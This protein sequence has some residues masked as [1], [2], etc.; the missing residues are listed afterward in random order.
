MDDAA[1]PLQRPAPAGATRAPQRRQAAFGFIFASALMNSVSFGIMI[2]ILPNLIRQFTGGDT[3]AAS[4]WNMVFGASWGLMQFFVGP[5]LGMLSDRVGRRPVLL[6]SFFG[7]AV[8]F[9]FMAFAPS[10][11][12]LYVGR[13][14]NGMTAS[15][16]STAG[17]YLADVTAPE[18]RAKSF[19]MLTSA[20]SFGFII[21]PT[22]GG[23][24]GEHSLRLPF[25]AAA[26][27]TAVNWFYGLL[28]LPESLPPERRLKA[29][30]WARANPLGSLRLLRGHPGLLGLAGVGFLFQLAQIVLPTI[31]VLYTTYRYGWTPGV[32]GLTFLLTGVLGVIVQMFLVGPAVAGLGERRVVLL[33]LLAGASGFVWYGA[34][35][36][37]WAYL[38][39]APIFALSG[40][41]MPGLQGLMTRRVSPSAQ[42]QLQGANQS[43]QGIASIVGPLIF[44]ETFAWSLRHQASLHSPGLAI[45]LSAGLLTLGFLLALR[46]AHAPAPER[47]AA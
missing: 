29:F 15:S 40:L 33:G 35:S 19:G 12:W 21:G 4:E 31:F 39:G 20:F 45:Y 3:A 16:F 6:I 32:L 1:A 8:D 27:I 14:L 2:P 17:A 18:R 30:N 41:I 46:T 9:L 24:L 7:L 36:V 37:G 34:A 42:G 25:L 44:G 23:V 11:W 43:L 13:I 22:I 47:P 10:L 5:I 38:L 26:A 28:I